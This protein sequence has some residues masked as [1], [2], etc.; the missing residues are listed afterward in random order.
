MTEHPTTNEDGDKLR[1]FRW[2]PRWPLAALIGAVVL[3]LALL[4]ADRWTRLETGED[5]GV[6]VF[7]HVTMADAGPLACLRKTF[8]QT[9][10]SI[11]SEHF[12]D[13][14]FLFHFILGCVRKWEEILGLPMGAPF[15]FDAL[16]FAALGVCAFAFAAYKTN[17]RKAF[18]F[19]LPF[20]FVAPGFT[21]RLLMLR[22]H[23]L[24]IILMVLAAV[25]F[26][27]IKNRKGL[28]IPAV[29]GFLYVYSYSNPHFLVFPA[30]AW[31]AVMAFQ[32]KRRLAL[33]LV[34]ATLL[35]LI[36]AMTLHPQFPNT[37]F[38]WKVQC[39]DVVREILFKD[40]EV[41]IGN[42]LVSPKPL[43]LLHNVAHPLLACVNMAL[44]FRL[45]R[46]PRWNWKAL[47]PDTWVYLALQTLFAI[48]LLV[49]LRFIE[50]GIPFAMLATLALW[51]DS[52]DDVSGSGFWRPAWRTLTAVLLAGALGMVVW[53]RCLVIGPTRE[54]ADFKRWAARHLPPGTL[55]ASLDWGDFPLLFYA[56]PHCKY[57]VGL[58]P[59]FGYAYNSD[60]TMKLRRLKA[61]KRAVSPEEL[62]RITGAKI[63]FVG[64]RNNSN[65][66]WAKAL[67][68][69]LGYDPI[70]LSKD[71]AAFLLPD[72]NAKSKKKNVGGAGK[73]ARAPSPRE[74]I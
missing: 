58:D 70:Y 12:Y 48:G 56:A 65:V 46:A 19:V 40:K 9:T 11:W 51:R 29:F 50:Y 63:A 62:A 74:G 45:L 64:F 8:P 71:G 5:L 52:S 26:A 17:A 10:M 69:Q 68:R 49:S 42:E 30:V 7:Y 4:A 66:M 44:A 73:P 43:W 22:P 25:F 38:V 13:K 14:E 60:A 28:W 23:H 57:L 36:V 3:T 15:N 24:S 32:G 16:F 33:E 2:K 53:G 18:L 55:V 1:G 47:R 35:S 6:D 21:S 59:T 41:G 34:G 61:G 54:F 31:G 37:F 27:K 67:V 20:A 39:V 72:P